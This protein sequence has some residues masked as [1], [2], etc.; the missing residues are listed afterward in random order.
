M[1]Q[2][3]LLQPPSSSHSSSK[4][5]SLPSLSIDLCPPSSSTLPDLST[6]PTPTAP[7]PPTQQHTTQFSDSEHS[8]DNITIEQ[9]NISFGEMMGKIFCPIFSPYLLPW[10]KVMGLLLYFLFLLSFLEQ[11][12][13]NH[14]S[15]GLINVLN[16]L[17]I[18]QMF[19][20]NQ[21]HCNFQHILTTSVS[22]Y[23]L[24]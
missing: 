12:R 19:L 17:R 4:F 3:N 2:Q 1:Q 10:G 13:A 23:F 15:Q 22:Y 16:N 7:S 6:T 20:I 21:E 9:G 18:Q 14:P 24:S 11:T 8:D 5:P